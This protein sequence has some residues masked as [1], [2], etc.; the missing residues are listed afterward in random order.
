[1]VMKDVSVQTIGY[2]VL[3]DTNGYFKFIIPISRQQHSYQL[4]LMKKGY[5]TTIKSYETESQP[6]RFIMEKN[7][8]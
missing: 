6:V 7:K 5:Q 3:T 4:T 2:S 1:M 8:N